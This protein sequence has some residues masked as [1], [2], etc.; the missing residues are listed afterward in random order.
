MFS[1]DDMSDHAS[2]N[3][4]FHYWDTK[5]SWNGGK[6]RESSKLTFNRSTYGWLIL[7][8]WAIT[9]TQ[10]HLESRHNPCN[11]EHFQT[12]PE[13]SQPYTSKGCTTI[14]HYNTTFFVARVSWWNKGGIFSEAILK[15]R[16]L[17]R[18]VFTSSSSSSSMYTQIA[19]PSLHHHSG[20]LIIEKAS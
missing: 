18:V 11:N 19:G 6:W 14:L 3:E 2:R 1:C 9:L 5:L 7:K 15:S 17:L 13:I 8:I 12:Y 10:W 16:W 4:V 20:V